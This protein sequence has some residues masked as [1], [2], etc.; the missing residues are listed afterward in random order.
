MIK[1]GDNVIVIAGKDKG[2]QGKVVRNV[3][4]RGQV[5]VEGVNVRL[6]RRKPRKSNEKG[7]TI[8]MTLPINASNVALYC[9]SCGKGV[10]SKAKLESGKKT[11]VCVKCG[12]AL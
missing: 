1:K 7:Q 8:S 4:S 3:I 2:K 11:R 10:R 6:R 12:K 5:A 9:S